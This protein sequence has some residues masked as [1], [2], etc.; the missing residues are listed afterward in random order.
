M[1]GGLA[2]MLALMAAPVT[3]QSLNHVETRLPAPEG[4]DQARPAW[5]VMAR[6]SEPTGRYAHGIM[7]N[8]PPW[9][10]LEVEALACGACR[11][12][13]ESARVALPETLVFEDVAPRLWDVTGDGRPEI[14]VVESDV[15]RGARLAVWSFSDIG[16]DLTRLAVT[17]FIGR[18][19]RWLAPLGVG[20]FD[21]DGRI[22]MAYV[23]RPHLAKELVMVR[24]EGPVLRE[25]YR[26]PGFSGHRI[27]DTTITSDVRT[28]S[29]G[30][31]QLLVPDGDWTRLLAVR[32]GQGAGVQF[33]EGPMTDGALSEAVQRACR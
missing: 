27:G 15:T 19:Q 10:V 32:L 2:L 29:D 16:A 23:D 1:R 6:L 17:P 7:G 18:P 4:R 14:V 26:A 5:P 28:C 13:S 31:A 24:L 8:I 11:H 21:G 20:D 12:G 30:S 22:E 33:D 25:I 3:A 9:S